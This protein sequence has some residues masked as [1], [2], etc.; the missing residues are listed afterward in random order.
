VKVVCFIQNFYINIIYFV[1]TDFIIKDTLIII[2]LFY[3]IYIKILNKTNNQAKSLKVINDIFNETERVSCC[4]S[5][6]SYRGGA[7]G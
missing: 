6:Q 1:I 5:S 3:I 4:L 7:K 2:Y